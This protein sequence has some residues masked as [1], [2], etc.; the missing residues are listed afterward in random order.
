MATA[1]NY[2]V[3]SRSTLATPQAGSLADALGMMIDPS[4]NAPPIREVEAPIVHPSPSQQR[5]CLTLI[6]AGVQVAGVEAIEVDAKDTIVG[7]EVEA[8]EV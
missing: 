2:Q 4:Y 1:K 7:D 5:N 3:T 8:I 6:E